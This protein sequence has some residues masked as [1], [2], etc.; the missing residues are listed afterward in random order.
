[1][2]RMDRGC[3]KHVTSGCLHSIAHL[4]PTCRFESFEMLTQLRPGVRPFFL[5]HP[6][7]ISV[8]CSW[9]E[10]GG[11]DSLY[12]SYLQGGSLVTQSKGC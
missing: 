11:G 7:P 5:Y 4:Q 3:A 1:M 2:R 8:L 9:P 12:E 6:E 10:R